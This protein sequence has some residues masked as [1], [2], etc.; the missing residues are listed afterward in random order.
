MTTLGAIPTDSHAEMVSLKQRADITWDFA[1][2]L[3]ARFGTCAAAERHLVSKL[4]GG[5]DGPA[6]ESLKRA[7]RAKAEDQ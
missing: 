4:A 7:C 5:L 1:A 2:E 3:I 6:L